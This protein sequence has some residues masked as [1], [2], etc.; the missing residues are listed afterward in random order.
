MEVEGTRQSEGDGVLGLAL[1][2]KLCFGKINLESKCEIVFWIFSD[3]FQINME[4]ECQKTPTK[5]ISSTSELL[6][7]MGKGKKVRGINTNAKK[8]RNLR[9]CIWFHLCNPFLTQL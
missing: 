2:I 1:N 4:T 3:N 5:K 9:C 8:L 6:E 7:R